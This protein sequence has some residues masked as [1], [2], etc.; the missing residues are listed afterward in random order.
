MSRSGRPR[1]PWWAWPSVLALDAPAVAIAWSWALAGAAGASFTVVEAAV[2]GL[3]TASVYLLDRR[4]DV[5]TIEH[6]PSA[7][8]RHV[9]AAGHLRAVS[10]VTAVTAMATGLLGLLLP[11]REIAWGLMVAAAAL[12][13][14]RG[15]RRHA[16]CGA[17]P[18]RRR[19]WRLRPLAVGVVFA[20]GVALPAVDGALGAVAP[21]VVLLAAVVALNVALIAAWESGLDDGRVEVAGG[22]SDSGRARAARVAAAA[23]LALTAWVARPWLAEVGAALAL[24]AIALALLE[25]VGRRWPSE[26]RHLVADGALLV[27]LLPVLGA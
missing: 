8:L 2:V 3:A 26:V 16:R 15:P 19:R 17:P 22:R 1:L 7:P 21:A 25:M 5:A 12:I 23:S 27:A 13:L 4:L 10:V 20:A 14:L 6:M 11:W 9:W 18:G 24:A